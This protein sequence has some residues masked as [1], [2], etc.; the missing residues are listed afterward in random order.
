MKSIANIANTPLNTSYYPGKSITQINNNSN[1][2]TQ[3]K[4]QHFNNKI[5]EEFKL[6]IYHY[7]L[8]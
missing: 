4:I 7:D 3:Q 6:Y 2:F 8:Q 1:L 5:H